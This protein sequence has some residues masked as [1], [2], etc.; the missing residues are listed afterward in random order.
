MGRVGRGFVLLVEDHG[1]TR[2]LFFEILT[3]AG[4][5]CTTAVSPAQAIRI[6]L[7]VRF[8][9]VLMDLGLPRRDDG[10]ALARE[11]RALPDPPPLIAVSGYLSDRESAG[12]FEAELL[13]PVDEDQLL[14][15]VG[16][17]VGRS[18]PC[19]AS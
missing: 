9:A 15:T 1:A 17:V 6:A 7:L 12:L 4:Y 19:D 11:L 10:L 13:K 14:A 16:R 18:G 3:D 8:D 5:S 2:A